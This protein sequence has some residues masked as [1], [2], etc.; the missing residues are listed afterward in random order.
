[1]WFDK[2]EKIL[3]AKKKR[4]KIKVYIVWFLCLGYLLLVVLDVHLL[5]LTISDNV[6]DYKKITE[7]GKDVFEVDLIENLKSSEVEKMFE[8]SKKVSTTNLVLLDSLGH[9]KHYESIEK[10]MFH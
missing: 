4:S 10:G 2:Y 6:Q 9:V 3:A 7:R 5:S 1:M 8:L